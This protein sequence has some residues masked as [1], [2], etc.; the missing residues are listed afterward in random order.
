M[1]G[2]VRSVQDEVRGRH[3]TNHLTV[4][5]QGV[6]SVARTAPGGTEGRSH[7]WSRVHRRVLPTRDGVYR[8]RLRRFILHIQLGGEF[9]IYWLFPLLR[10]C[11]RNVLPALGRFWQRSE[12]SDVVVDLVDLVVVVPRFSRASPDPRPVSRCGH[13]Q[14]LLRPEVSANT[15]IVNQY[16][17]II[18][19][20]RVRV[21]VF[22]L[23]T[24]TVE[25]Q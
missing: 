14:L 7:R 20:A 6:G 11:F 9:L 12:A 23:R 8:R 2:R 18:R 5:A 1:V 13:N 15:D 10:G 19:Q 24:H 25:T 17:A 21:R 4:G 3:Y 22:N 16:P